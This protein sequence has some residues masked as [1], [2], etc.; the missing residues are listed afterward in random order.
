MAS[1]GSRRKSLFYREFLYAGR[2]V[3]VMFSDTSAP[4]EHRVLQHSNPNLNLWFHNGLGAHHSDMGLN[5]QCRRVDANPIYSNRFKEVGFTAQEATNNTHETERTGPQLNGLGLEARRLR[6]ASLYVQSDSSSQEGRP[7]RWSQGL[8]PELGLR[9]TMSGRSHCTESSFVGNHRQTLPHPSVRKCLTGTALGLAPPTQFKGQDGCKVPAC[10]EDQLQGHSRQTCQRDLSTFSLMDSATVT[11]DRPRHQSFSSTL[12]SKKGKSQNSHR[13]MTR[14][15]RGPETRLDKKDLTKPVEGYNGPSCL[16][17]IIFSTEIPQKNMKGPTPKPQQSPSKSFPTTEDIQT[18]PPSAN[19]GS[20]RGTSRAGSKRSHQKVVRDQIQRVVKNLEEV[21]GGLK[22]VHQEMK[23]VVQQIELLTSSIDL[24]E[25]EASPSLHSDSSS[26]SSSS[27]VAMSS[28][29]QRPGGE[30]ARPG[31]AALSSHIRTHLPQP[32]NPPS[33]PVCLPRQPCPS[34]SSSI[35]PNTPGV[36]PLTSNRTNPHQT[37]THDLSVKTKSPHYP[38]ITL[39]SPNKTSLLYPINPRSSAALYH[40]LG[41]SPH[42]GVPTTHTPGPSVTLETHTGPHMGDLPVSPP[43]D[44][45]TQTQGEGVMPASAKSPG[46]NPGQTA[47]QGQ[48]RV[49]GSRGHKPPPYPHNRHSDRVASKGKDP[50]K[51][52]P[53]PVKRRLLS[54]TV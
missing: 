32:H 41:L 15:A 27:G 46:L 4:G 30:E 9:H 5:G 8:S 45:E 28:G 7:S 23:E 10:L 11:Q 51:A 12:S 22:D 34:K 19:Q 43:R 21:L 48:G 24:S 3:S 39:S 44:R 26:T 36:S 53:Y 54:T 13:D 50:R 6:F 16:H 47:P 49:P 37:N 35:R 20:S 29:R 38:H 25:G 17:E 31:A 18:R 40:N 2:T 1:P 33:R 52:P 14:P 42:R